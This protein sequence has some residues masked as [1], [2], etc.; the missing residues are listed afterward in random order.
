MRVIALRSGSSLV[1]AKLTVTAVSS[2][3]IAINKAR[4]NA[5]GYSRSAAVASGRRLSRPMR[6]IQP[7]MISSARFVGRFSDQ[8]KET[9]RE[10]DVR[11]TV[12]TV[13]ALWLLSSQVYL[14]QRGPTANP[15]ERNAD[16][17]R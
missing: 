4:H 11:L 13:A 12:L 8:K 10:V 9:H 3:A 14:A 2:A 17:A 6:D 1:C 15:L 16:A 5:N 7:P